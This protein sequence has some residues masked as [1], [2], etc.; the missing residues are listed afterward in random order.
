MPNRLE[1]FCCGR[2][3][4]FMSVSILKTSCAL[5]KCSSAFRTPISLNTFRLPVSYLFLVKGML[6]LRLRG[7]PMEGINREGQI[8]EEGHQCQK[9]PNSATDTGDSLADNR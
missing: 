9:R 2:L 6:P 4:T 8:D 3:R 7:I 1:G 5:T